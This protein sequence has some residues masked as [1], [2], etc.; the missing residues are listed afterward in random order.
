MHA[1]RLAT[2]ASSALVAATLAGF[3]APAAFAKGPEHDPKLDIFQAV[4]PH[5]VHGKSAT[6]PSGLSPAKVRAAYNLPS[7]G[8]SGT[9]AIVDAYDYPTAESD[10]NAF[11]SQFGLPS[12]TKANGCFEKHPMTSNVRA[13]AGWALE[14]SLDIEW[15]HA[16]APSA[17]ILLVEARSASGTDLLAAVDY[18]RNRADVVAVSMSWGG[19]E[20]SS[21][22]SSDSHFTSTHGVTFF[23]SSGDSGT[24]AEWPAVSPNVVAVGG[25]TLTFNTDGSLASETA[26]SGSG[27]GVSAYEAMPSYQSAFGLAGTMRLLPD[28]SYVA[29]PAS[30]VAVYDTTTYQGQRGWF[31]VGGTSAGSPQW[32]AIRALGGTAAN[33]ALYA[34]ATASYATMFRDVMLGT[35]GNCGAVCS[36]A[37]GYDTVTGLGSPLT[38]AF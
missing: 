23:S 2:F 25:T 30:G 3:L 16:I 19:N 38:A 34:D 32:A 37:A 7:T 26:W 1:R 10:L 12:C 31:K 28:V 36:A 14:E 17:K 20:F 18:A 29:D 5:H 27:G 11:S 13:N 9:I 8:G 4:P 22:V 15:A 21:E 24:G 6:A 33:P 35:N